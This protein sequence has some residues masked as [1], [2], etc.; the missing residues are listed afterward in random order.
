MN[1]GRYQFLFG[2]ELVG[3]QREILDPGTAWGLIYE[4]VVYIGPAEIRKFAKWRR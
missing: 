2:R 1:I 3:Y 4:W